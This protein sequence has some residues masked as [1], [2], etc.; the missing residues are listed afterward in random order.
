MLP[1]RVPK[2]R[3]TL[4]P[5]PMVHS[6]I[7]VG[8][9]ESPKRSPPALGEKYKV[10]VHGAPH[11]RKAYIQWGAAWFPKGIVN[12]TAIS[13]PVPCSILKETTENVTRRTQVL[14]LY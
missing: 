2:D 6:F 4:S 12:N 11:T 14:H 7:H 13:I 1:N 3:N 5:E 10:T 8:L 9:L